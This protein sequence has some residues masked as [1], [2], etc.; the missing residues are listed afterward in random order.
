MSK[1]FNILFYTLVIVT[2]IY[3]ISKYETITLSEMLFF[4][5][6]TFM[7]GIVVTLDTIS[8]IKSQIN[9]GAK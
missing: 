3:N 2:T 9:K 5:V 1:I 6:K 7:F 4:T 8:F